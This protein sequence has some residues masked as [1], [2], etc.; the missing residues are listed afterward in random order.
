MVEN[1]ARPWPGSHHMTTR[2]GGDLRI[3]GTECLLPGKPAPSPCNRTRPR[4]LGN[5]TTLS[6]LPWSGSRQTE[7]ACAHR[8]G[9]FFCHLFPPPATGIVR[10]SLTETGNPTCLQSQPFALLRPPCPPDSRVRS[11]N[12]ALRSAWRRGRSSPVN[13]PWPQAYAVPQVHDERPQGP[14]TGSSSLRRSEW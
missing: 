8:P 11:S 3:S 9:I 2:S 10:T 13:S 6:R 5:N 14:G 12:R 7:C 1:V 4:I